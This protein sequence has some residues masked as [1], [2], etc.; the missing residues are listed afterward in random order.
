MDSVGS[1][2]EENQPSRQIPGLEVAGKEKPSQA[3]IE[4]WSRDRTTKLS[5]ICAVLF[6]TM[7]TLIVV[8]KM[9]E[10]PI[11]HE[12]VRNDMDHIRCGSEGH[13]GY[14]YKREELSENWLIYLESSTEVGMDLK[15]G[16]LCAS[17]GSDEV[18]ALG[19][20][21]ELDHARPDEMTSFGGILSSDANK[22][23]LFH[24]W[25]TIVIPWCSGYA[26]TSDRSFSDGFTVQGGVLIHE[27]LSQLDF[28]E[29]EKV[30]LAGSGT[31]GLQ[32]LLRASTLQNIINND[33]TQVF[34]IADSA[35]FLDTK[36]EGKP[37]KEL[38]DKQST[39]FPFPFSVCNES[40][41]SL[42]DCLWPKFWLQH[43]RPTIPIFIIQSWYDSW[44]LKNY[45]QLECFDSTF[46][47]TKETCVSGLED[48]H[49]FRQK[50]EEAIGLVFFGEESK[51]IGTDDPLNKTTGFWVTTCP[52]HGFL[53]HDDSYFEEVDEVW[54]V[55]LKPLQT[56]IREWM[57]SVDVDHI[58]DEDNT[59]DIFSYML[60]DHQDWSETIKCPVRS[61]PTS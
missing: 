60:A 52:G 3:A 57:E 8:A 50:L 53:T 14:Y 1:S 34:V 19:V 47:Y 12:Y 22:N 51:R 5:I 32:A 26:F 16:G 38:Y 15:G 36:G 54:K 33:N 2:Y 56:T 25:N 23:Q 46:A 37:L 10:E 17:S 42:D 28:S 18:A 49:E 58:G 59:V 27:V 43:Q 41:I 45:L 61:N 35:F 9:Q 55:S 44:N 39:S 20:C 48:A 6:I 21:E 29:A 7:V 40:N 31:G 24:S 13:N 30:V 11:K 4:E